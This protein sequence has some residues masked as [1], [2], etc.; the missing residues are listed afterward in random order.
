MLIV[1]LI[2]IGAALLAGGIYYLTVRLWSKQQDKP[3]AGPFKSLFFAVFVVYSI[4]L[5]GN[6]LYANWQLAIEQSDFA[7][8]LR[9]LERKQRDEV[10]RI[11]ETYT[12]EM[13]F[14]DWRNQI[15]TSANDLE[16][17][18]A[19]AKTKYKLTADDERMWRAAAEN[20]TLEKLVPKRSSDD[21]LKE[22]QSRLKKSLGQIRS[23]QTLMASDVRILSENI[24]AI[25][26]IGKEYEKVLD[27]FRDLYNTLTT[28]GAEPVEPKQEYFLFFP[29]KKKE[30]QQL[31]NEF[32]EAKGNQKALSEVAVRLK[33][34]I[35][36]AETEMNAIN[37]K[38]EANLA[39]IETDSNTI[40]FNNTKLEKLIEATLKEAE[41]I[42]QSDQQPQ[43]RIKNK[44]SQ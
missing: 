23:G 33:A 26:L 8:Q 6:Q 11:V 10:K 18:L 42:K 7:K 32:H 41:I 28:P 25:R 15:F 36:K 19:A 31:L 9:T 30:Y 22:Y 44:N 38:F 1:G 20:N 21:V 4:A 43:F 12:K 39:F 5:I 37:Q 29:V 40:S 35:E 16:R 14:Q 2:I 13:A 24:N 34:A 17:T 3:A 27:T